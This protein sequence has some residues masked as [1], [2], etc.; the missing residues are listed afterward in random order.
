MEFRAPYPEDQFMAD[1]DM[2][3][4]Y[5]NC[6]TKSC[7]CVNKYWLFGVYMQ[8]ENI[9]LTERE[10]TFGKEYRAMYAEFIRLGTTTLKSWNELEENQF[11]IFDFGAAKTEAIFQ[12]QCDKFDDIDHWMKV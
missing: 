6:L 8:D 10:I 1:T 7:H 11:N 12:L 5:E 3:M 9:K 2:F 4:D